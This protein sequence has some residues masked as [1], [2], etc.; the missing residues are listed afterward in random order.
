M[1]ELCLPDLKNKYK[2]GCYFYGTKLNKKE[3][4]IKDSQTL[5]NYIA[6]YAS[7]PPISERRI[8]NI[9]YSKNLVTWFFDPHEDD[10]IN[11]EDK[12]TW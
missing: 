7:H 4:T 9:D 2:D 11:D 3:S 12:K 1:K 5:T 6:R 8:V 10:D